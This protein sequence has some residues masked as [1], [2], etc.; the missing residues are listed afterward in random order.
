MPGATLLN[1]YGSSEDSADVT[2]FNTTENPEASSLTV[3][4]GK[5]FYN[6]KI[7]I[8]DKAGLPTPIGIVG[9]IYAGGI[10]LAFGY[11]N[12]PELTAKSFNSF[13]SHIFN[14]PPAPDALLF[15]TGDM[16][17]FLS[18]GNI[19]FFGRRDQ[20]VK[21][22]G[23]RIEPGEIE[24][25]LVGHEQV[26]EAVVISRKD[27]SGEDYLC[28]YV[29]IREG[30]IDTGILKEFVANRL[31]HYMVPSFIV[32]LE[33]MPL[34]ATG[35][36]SRRLLPEPEISSSAEYV[37]PTGKSQ[38]Q[39]TALW[40]EVLGSSDDTP[41]GIHDDFFQMGGHS[42]KG[43]VLVA[44]I[45]KVFDIN[46][47]L[48]QLFETPTIKGLERYI[49]TSAQE[50]AS[51]VEPVETKEYY[52][53]SSAQKRLYFLYQME[54]NSISYNIPFVLPIRRE[55]IEK[56]K[57]KSVLKQL[58][59][60]HE[61]LRT[62]FEV[63]GEQPVQRV[64]NSVEFEIETIRSRGADQEFIS[65]F[66]RPFDLSRAPLMRSA[67]I[68]LSDN[69]YIWL[70]DIHHIVSD[71]I[72]NL[73]LMEEFSAL[74]NGEVPTLQPLRL[75][76]KDF[77]QWQDQL[78]QSPMMEKQ[79][80][81]WQELYS[82][83]HEIG[84]LQLP[85]DYP[86]PE[87]FTARGSRY[88][89]TLDADLVTSFKAF[90]ARSGGTLYM[91]ILALL[92]V[93]FY[94]YSGQTDIII[95]S[96]IAGRSHADL[97]RIVGVFINTLAMRNHPE[98][99]KDYQSFIKE[100]AGRSLNAFEN[101]D[102]QLEELIA[103]L[104]VERDL[105]RNPLF[106]VFLMIQNFNEPSEAQQLTLVDDA[107]SLPQYDKIVS[108]FDLTFY[109]DE[110]PENI[111]ITIEYYTGI[112]HPDTVQ[113]MARH[114][115]TLLAAVLKAPSRQLK[116]IQII[117]AE[118]KKQ[119]LEEFNNTAM[120]FPADKTIHQLFR[121]QVNKRPDDI[122]AL[123]ETAL[124]YRKLDEEAQRLSRYLN[125]KKAVRTEDRIGI[126]L[127]RSLRLPIALLA[128]LKAG[129]A[130]VPIDPLLPEERIKY[131]INDA[132]VAVLISESQYLKQLNRL[133][134]QC[135]GF[136]EY[137][138]LDGENRRDGLYSNDEISNGQIRNLSSASP[139]THP[140]HSS[141]DAASLAYVIY[142]SGSTGRPKGVMISH[143][144]VVNFS[145]AVALRIPF[146][147][148]K[149]MLALTTVSFDI[150]V[151]ENF[152]PLLKGMK[153]VFASNLQHSDP[154]ELAE[155]I[156]K[157]RV[158]MAQFTPSGI[159]WMINGCDGLSWAH[160]VRQL[161]VGGEAF[162]DDL[163]ATI[164]RS[165]N[166]EIYNMYG[167]TET[168][169]WSA[170]SHLKAKQKVDIGSPILNTSI[171]ILGE[172]RSLQPI[173]VPGELCIGGSGVARGYL[174]QPQLTA[175]RFTA[176]PF[177]H[178][179]H[180]PH[181]ALSAHSTLYRTG[182]LARWLPA[183]TIQFLGRRDF[184]VKIRGF[185]VELGEIESL[186][187]KHPEIREAVVI[188]R[189]V[190]GS[191]ENLAE[192]K[193]LCAYVVYNGNEDPSQSVDGEALSRCL[194]QDLP[195]YMIP[196]SFVAIAEVPLTLSGK[197]NRNQLPVPEEQLSRQSHSIIAPRNHI[198]KT[199]V[200]IWSQVLRISEDGIGID[201]HFFRMGGHSLRATLLVSRIK[202]NCWP[203]CPYCRCL[204]LPQ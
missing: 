77:A 95:G 72:S 162:S 66:A 58:I 171:I 115:K 99:Q 36:I 108:R 181:S 121:E 145:E 34:T 71:G 45:Q 199:L 7:Y 163:F 153:V 57:L 154:H 142:T 20:Q 167:P 90:V 16:G 100:V 1:I 97:Q 138:C 150:F 159:R 19:E 12:K 86:R 89:F 178:D 158:Q 79:W 69:N 27:R 106:D 6:I 151:L 174:N 165:F 116:D 56:A 137:I 10:C 124:S 173:G 87:V 169:V 35:K 41:L 189:T 183:G 32:Q 63:I 76:Y 78:L 190:P 128:V 59:Q 25:L 53:L 54:Q 39:L 51:A 82:D 98:G 18:D 15:G 40:R 134:E 110:E 2:C 120:D 83:S 203:M 136:N 170:I 146:L 187:L 80:H 166:G 47:P 185:R 144:N 191:G 193:Y 48:T 160:G 33:K 85:A 5:P 184:Q 55:K 177:A 111:N 28:A 175:E 88:D 43:M 102:V 200:Q 64:Q 74:Y 122:A 9:E 114:F 104:D 194:A 92:N 176:N 186:L 147:P 52:P 38:I 197:V 105:S 152:L 65:R 204:K 112:F 60:W 127:S 140:V 46:L 118:E 149:T 156:I 157:N 22:R 113:R 70:M 101:Q 26:T 141:Q 195:G 37:Q 133:Q 129:A 94:K 67:L 148:R 180:E 119:L 179:S 155:L 50:S 23:S 29:V 24:S 93:L 192:E 68:E 143:R 130:Y 44:K 139:S 164:S 103:R 62:S 96:G 196:S 132:S 125:E 8:L 4:I 107:D 84:H 30:T 3:P 73:I 131:M 135:D 81:Y 31:P 201:G 117:S 161:I 109:V 75:Q 17:R 172:G 182:D 123:A 61:S 49:A 13:N 168:T 11:L 202:K 14:S 91:N 21:V 198:E 188:D 42:L 126:L